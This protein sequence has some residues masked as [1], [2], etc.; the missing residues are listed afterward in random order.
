VLVRGQLSDHVEAAWIRWA[1]TARVKR[2]RD[3]VRRL[4]RTKLD[5]VAGPPKLRPWEKERKKR[6]DAK[7]DDGEEATLFASELEGE[8]PTPGMKLPPPEPLLPIS[9]K[10]WLESI[11]RAPGMGLERLDR[12]TSFY[13][14]QHQNAAL[15]CATD[16]I[17]L[18]L[19]RELAQD[20]VGTIHAW[21]GRV[22]AAA[23]WL[24]LNESENRPEGRDG[25]KPRKR[26]G[27]PDLEEPRKPPGARDI[28]EPRRPFDDPA[29]L[30][31]LAVKAARLFTE[32][33][34]RPPMWV[35]FL[36]LLENAFRAWDDPSL[37][38]KREW[39]DTYRKAG[40][41][42]MVPGC[43]RRA[44][45][46]NHHIAF[47]NGKRV[48]ASWNLVC[49]CPFHHQEG[50]HG[51]LAAVWGRSPLGLVFRLDRGEH[52]RYF[53]NEREIEMPTTTA[54]RPS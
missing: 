3:E 35:G 46:Q 28:G 5:T 2:L 18:R 15:P 23:L 45:L 40:W 31:M 24:D 42:C 12:W 44:D 39:E 14:G 7:P 50:I 10:A 1:V 52:A 16:F 30:T 38:E 13:V 33:S 32:R 19:R 47:G 37:H 43:T 4:E 26:L 41:R 53:F 6:R 25:G 21:H 51:G 36:A 54:A 27:A 9:D 22:T 20:L 48:D 17:D 34:R 49:L 8:L 11:Y 29:L